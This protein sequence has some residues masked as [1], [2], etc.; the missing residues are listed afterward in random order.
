M[1]TRNSFQDDFR[2]LEIA[3]DFHKFFDTQEKKTDIV[4]TRELVLS[5]FKAAWEEWGPLISL[6]NE[7]YKK[8]DTQERVENKAEDNLAAWLAVFY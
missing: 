2:M 8:T 3:K 6:I 4:L 5:R 7:Q 1:L